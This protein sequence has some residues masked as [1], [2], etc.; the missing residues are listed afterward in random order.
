MVY[1]TVLPQLA[2]AHHSDEEIKEGAFLSNTIPKFESSLPKKTIKW[3]G[4]GSKMLFPK[5]SENEEDWI[6]IYHCDCI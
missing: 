5:L 6:K 3:G 4:M 1:S 2:G